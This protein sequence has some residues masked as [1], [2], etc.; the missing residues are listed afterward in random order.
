MWKNNSNAY[1]DYISNI[2]IN[3]YDNDN[4]KLLPIINT[5]VS[6]ADL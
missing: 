6:F 5:D 4:N 2:L 1:T 3:Y